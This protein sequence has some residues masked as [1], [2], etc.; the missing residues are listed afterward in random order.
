MSRLPPYEV[1]QNAYLVNDVDE[2]VGRLTRTAGYGPWMILRHVELPKVWYRGKPAVVDMSAA[3][4]QA[5]DVQIELIQQHN[6]APSCY[7]DLYP[8]GKQGFHH[9]AMFV[10]D[11]EEAKK[12]YEDAGCPC[13][14]LFELPDGGLAAYMDTSAVN[15]HMIEIYKESEG[16]RALYRM[17]REFVADNDRDAVMDGGSINR[18]MV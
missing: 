4:T 10:P 9:T 2:A 12:A 5:G 18:I 17:V 13:A 3:F 6:D 11:Y 1:I 16:I 7:R 14:Q 15:G 8:K